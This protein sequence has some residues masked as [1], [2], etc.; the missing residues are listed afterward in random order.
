MK[1]WSAFPPQADHVLGALFSSAAAKGALWVEPPH[2]CLILFVV[3]VL[4][5]YSYF[6]FIIL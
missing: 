1:D 4:F 5:Y 2:I 3:M 6:V